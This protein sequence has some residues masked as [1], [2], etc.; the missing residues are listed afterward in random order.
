MRLTGVSKSGILSRNLG[1]LTDLSSDRRLNA[2]SPRM[3]SL[4]P[5]LPILRNR[6]ILSCLMQPIYTMSHAW[7]PSLHAARTQCMHT[8]RLTSIGSPEPNIMGEKAYTDAFEVLRKR[9]YIAGSRYFRNNSINHH[10]VCLKNKQYCNI[11][12]WILL[13]L[14]W[15]DFP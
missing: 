13:L 6:E 7:L 10:L 12:W 11:N 4:P 15:A 1:G 9:T 14:S 3:S 8:Y 5:L 2:W